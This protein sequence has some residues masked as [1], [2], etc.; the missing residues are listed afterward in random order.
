MDN[1]RDSERPALKI[2]DY[3]TLLGDP[4][5]S[6]LKIKDYLAMLD[7][8]QRSALKIKDYLAMLDDPQRSALK[9]KKRRP[10]FAPKKEASFLFRSSLVFTLFLVYS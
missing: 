6:A 7:D 9:T 8:P 4:Q 2:K 3:L 5:R 10:R 1:L